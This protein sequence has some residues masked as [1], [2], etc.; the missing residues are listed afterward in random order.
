MPK[1]E[2]DKFLEEMAPFFRILGVQAVI[3]HE[4]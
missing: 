4:P 3:L 2:N 1:K